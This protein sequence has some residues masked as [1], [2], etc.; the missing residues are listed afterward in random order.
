MA[1]LCRQS[2]LPSKIL[3][4]SH[5]ILALLAVLFHLLSGRLRITGGIP[6]LKTHVYLG[7]IPSFSS[8][9]LHGGLE[10]RKPQEVHVAI[11]LLVVFLIAFGKFKAM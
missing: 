7:A 5:P 11:L 9:F 1:Y 6:I 8:D 2:P 10:L 3:P 4:A